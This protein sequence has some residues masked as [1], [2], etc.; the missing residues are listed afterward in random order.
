M[1][2]LYTQKMITDNQ[3]NKIYFMK[4]VGTAVHGISGHQGSEVAIQ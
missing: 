2:I 1:Q 4:S 3:T